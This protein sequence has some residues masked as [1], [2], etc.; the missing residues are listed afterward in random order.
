MADSGI[1]V[2]GSKPC[3]SRT[4]EPPTS[5]GVKGCRVEKEKMQN[6][7]AVVIATQKEDGATEEA[8]SKETFGGHGVEYDGDDNDIEVEF[9]K[10]ETNTVSDNAAGSDNVLSASDEEHV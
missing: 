1:D 7:K 4:A 5:R 2:A 8:D 9:K 3:T 6:A 10:G